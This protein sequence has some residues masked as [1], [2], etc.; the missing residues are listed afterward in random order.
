MI[1]IFNNVYEIKLAKSLSY[2]GQMPDEQVPGQG[3]F[4]LWTLL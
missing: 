3:L 2:V 4:S 1:Y